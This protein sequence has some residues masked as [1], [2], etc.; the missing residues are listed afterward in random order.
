MI[1]ERLSFY[2]ES[3]GYKKKAFCEKHGFVYNN[4][5]SVLSGK[6]PLGINVLNKVKESL[7]DLN[8]EWLLYGNGLPDLNLDSKINDPEQ[9][10]VKSDPL[11]D[12]LLN[13]MEKGKVHKLIQKMINDANK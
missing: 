11:E 7:P 10:V 13:Y 2:I 1:G 5:V 12:L 6:M 4:F 3:K 8:I 9:M